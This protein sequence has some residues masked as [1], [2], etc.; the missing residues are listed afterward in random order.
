MHRSV[1]AV[2]LEGEGEACINERRQSHKAGC[3]CVN[4]PTSNQISTGAEEDETCGQ[5]ESRCRDDSLRVKITIIPPAL[6]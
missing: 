1:A 3:P 2:E 4:I 5:E 6:G